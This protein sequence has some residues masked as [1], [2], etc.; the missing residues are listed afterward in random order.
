MKKS[1]K[2][3]PAKVKKQ[4]DKLW[5]ELV[6]YRDGHHCRVNGCL[7]DSCHAHHIFSRRHT[8]TRFD[9]SNGISL[10]FAHHKYWAH[11]DYEEF[12]EW[13]IREIGKK[14]YERLYE[15]S[16]IDVHWKLNDLMTIRDQ[17]KRMVDR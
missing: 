11:V 9:V 2:P 5:S 12:R 15:L 8:S 6:R 16:K 4:L 7:H 3:T 14:E 1:N 13:V 17:L 10:C